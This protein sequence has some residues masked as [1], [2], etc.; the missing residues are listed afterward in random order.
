MTRDNIR[1]TAS[2]LA[3]LWTGVDIRDQL[4]VERI[5]RSHP[6]ELRP[7][8]CAHV[9][10]YLEARGFHAAAVSFEAMLFDMAGVEVEQSAAVMPLSCEHGVSLR[11]HTA[12]PVCVSQ[13]VVPG[14]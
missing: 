6:V 3:H 7:V 10:R 8:I 2:T 4:G 12:C 14:T 9:M 11:N 1:D 5:I 13:L